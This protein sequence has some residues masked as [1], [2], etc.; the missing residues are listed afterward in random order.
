MQSAGAVDTAAMSDMEAVEHTRGS[1]QKLRAE[2]AK[3]IVGQ[4]AVIEQLLISIFAGGHCLL[5]GVPGLA[6]TLMVSSL[7]EALSLEFKRIQFTPDLMPS[8]IVGT[9]VIVMDR[10]AEGRAFKF[11]HGPIFANVILA[12]EINRTPPKTQAAMLEAME[13]RQVSAGGERYPMNEPFFVLATQNPIEQEGTYPLAAAQ[14]DRFMFKT[15]VDYPSREEEEEIVRVTTSPFKAQLNKLFE[16]DEILRLQRIV[17]QARISDEVMKY[18]IDIVRYTRIRTDQ[19]HWFAQEHLAW[20]AGPRAAQFL[21]LGGKA[22][23]ILFGRYDVLPED[24]RAIILPVMRHR[25]I[26]NFAADSEGVSTDY[27]IREIIKDVPAPDGWHQQYQVKKKKGFF[28]K[29]F[30]K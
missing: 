20:G 6:K 3:R 28:A 22:R 17:R 1:Y 16:K 5:E 10:S 26:C 19:A 12:D 14:L 2:L 7:A 29:L 21:I 24:I 15:F 25:I 27:I 30:G 23:A 11:L 18:V 9:E 13:E 8:D 4:D